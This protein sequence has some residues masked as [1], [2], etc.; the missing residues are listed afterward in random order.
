MSEQIQ[1]EKAQGL[2]AMKNQLRQKPMPKTKE[3]FQIIIEK[4]AAVARAQAAP[5]APVAAAAAP[6][7]APKAPAVTIADRRATAAIDRGAVLEKLRK[8]QGQRVAV[9]STKAEAPA[10]AAAEAPAAAAA[11]APAAAAAEAPAE[12]ITIKRKPRKLKKKL[13][14]VGV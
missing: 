11:E 7:D 9:G 10:P 3:V 14:V 8:R 6:R 13:K 1:D 12:T 2:A 4:P 5:A